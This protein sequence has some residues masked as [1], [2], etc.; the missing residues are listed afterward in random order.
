MSKQS[1]SHLLDIIVTAAIFMAGLAGLYQA[2]QFPGRSG[3]WPTFVMV[4]LLLFVG[5]HLTNLFRKL[6]Q[7][8]TKQEEPASN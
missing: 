5:V 4:A 2:L 3:M 8:D 7:T 1:K 6:M